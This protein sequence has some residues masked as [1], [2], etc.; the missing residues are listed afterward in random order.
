MREK[1]AYFKVH[2]GGGTEKKHQG[3]V[4][5]G[6]GTLRVTGIEKKCN[7]VS[8]GGTRNTCIG[9]G[10]REGRTWAGGVKIKI[11]KERVYSSR[12]NVTEV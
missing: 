3:K 2:P 8:E 5:G 9:E 11:E 6:G 10:T 7:S 4:L 1:T 12:D